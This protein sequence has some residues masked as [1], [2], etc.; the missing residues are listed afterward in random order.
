MVKIN[1]G[2]ED[3]KS[4]FGKKGWL[5]IWLAGIAFWFVTGTTVDGLNVIL[6]AISQESG[7]DYNGLLMWSTPAAW[8]SIPGG[9]LWAYLCNKKGVKFTM[10]STL[11][12]SAVLFALYG[13]SSNMVMYVILAAAVNLTTCGFSHVAANTLMASWFPRKKGLALGWAT[14]GQNL[15]T[16]LF[17]P[18]VSVLIAHFGCGLGLS[19]ISLMMIAF[20]AVVAFLVKNTPEECGC[21]P[22][23]D[24]LTREEINE[25][26]KDFNEYKSPFTTKK[27]LSMK[28][29]WLIG[30]GFGA[31]YMVTI[32]LVSQLVPR[33]IALGYDQGT[34]VSFMTIAAIFGCFGSYC[35][36]WLDQMLTTRKASIV[37]AFWYIAALILQCLPFTKATMVASIFMIG[38]GIGGIGNLASSIVATKFG[39][40]DFVKAWG[41]IFPIMSIVRCCAYAVLGFGLA[42]LG[43]YA[44]AYMLF[45]GVNVIAVFLIYKLDDTCIGKSL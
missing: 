14:I 25:L 29:T 4:N 43:G 28:E 37:Y 26:M 10:V 45:I 13:F 24:A 8:C 19:W 23:N 38:F 30:V 31:L 40:Y 18:L 12:V 16:A 36:G 35:W 41:V 44:G 42:H 9:V 15:S 5:M 1:F 27:L 20:A 11:V 22:D 3:T 17:V 34:A 2:N 39:R 32:G 21:T 33:L 6:A 7:L